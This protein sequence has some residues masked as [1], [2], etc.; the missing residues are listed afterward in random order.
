MPGVPT[1]CLPTATAILAETQISRRGFGIVWRTSTSASTTN[2]KKVCLTD[3]EAAPFVLH[4]AVCARSEGK[5][6]GTE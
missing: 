4:P 5:A 3:Y 6:A 1:E 2:W